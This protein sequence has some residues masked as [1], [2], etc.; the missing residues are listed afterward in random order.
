MQEQLSSC[1]TYFTE[2][3]ISFQ[4]GFYCS[5]RISLFEKKNLY[6]FIVRNVFSEL[7]SLVVKCTERSYDHFR[8]KHTVSRPF[9]HDAIE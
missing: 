7:I 9:S 5:F 1:A 3:L 4:G 2:I 6:F 8:M